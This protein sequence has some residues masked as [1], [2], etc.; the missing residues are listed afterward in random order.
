M[1]AGMSVLRAGWYGGGM[2]PDL[3]LVGPKARRRSS[4]DPR[5]DLAETIFVVT[6][7][8]RGKGCPDRVREGDD[9]E[10]GG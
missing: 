4:W 2:G 5:R 7:V 9:R 10:V 1:T 8:M 3:R 6:E